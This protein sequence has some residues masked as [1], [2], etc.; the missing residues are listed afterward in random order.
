V[1]AHERFRD[2]RDAGRS[3]AAKLQAYAGRR[4]VLVLA[5]PRGGVAVAYEVARALN[6]PLDLA[7]VRKLGVPGREELAFGAIGTGGVTV[8][9]EDVI[10]ALRIDRATIDEV[11]AR[12]QMELARRVR[13]YRNDRPLPDLR[14][15][16]LIVVDDGLATGASMLAA[17]AALRVHQPARIVV[18]IPVAAAET[19]E[20]VRRAADELV[21]CWTPEPFGGVG[22]WYENFTQLRDAD[23]RRF[24]GRR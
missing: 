15:A 9:N 1:E 18:A 14:G 12:E 8:L 20:L 22:A 6:A 7:I 21:C 5:L 3:L 2:R 16:T 10:D 17:V 23:V 4:D 24:L 11:I 19:C 13:R